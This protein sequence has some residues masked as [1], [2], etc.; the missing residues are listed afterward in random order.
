MDMELG[1]ISG[2]LGKFFRQGLFFGYSRAEDNQA[3]SHYMEG[4]IILYLKNIELI[5]RSRTGAL[6]WMRRGKNQKVGVVCR[7]FSLLMLNLDL[8]CEPL[9]TFS[10]IPSA[11]VS[12]A[13][14]QPYNATLS[15]HQLVETQM[16]HSVLAMRLSM[17]FA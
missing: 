9:N 10:V 1:T 15:V 11:K 12:D 3:K 4:E 17:T 5:H 7:G 13:V 14:V 16:R 2:P 8:E 6:Y